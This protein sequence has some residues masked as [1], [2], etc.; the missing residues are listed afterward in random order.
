MNNTTRHV[1]ARGSKWSVATL[2]DGWGDITDKQITKCVELVV[3]EF[4]HIAEQHGSSANWTPATAQVTA[5]I[6][7]D[8]ASETLEEWQQ[9]AIGYTWAAV[10]GDPSPLTDEVAAIF[11]PAQ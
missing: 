3:H 4:H 2:N 9:E 8:I 10:I 1:A 7:E 6:T 11:A 5:Y